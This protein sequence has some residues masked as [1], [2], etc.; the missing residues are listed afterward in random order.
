MSAIPSLINFA[1]QSR[2][3]RWARYSDYLK[4]IDLI[5]STLIFTGTQCTYLNNTLVLSHSEYPFFSLAIS[6]ESYYSYWCVTFSDKRLL[7]GSV[8]RCYED[9]QSNLLDILLKFITEIESCI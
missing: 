2:K 1:R 8:F 3:E 9:R 5:S 4:F 7:G 6:K